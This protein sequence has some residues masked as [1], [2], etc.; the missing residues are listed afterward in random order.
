MSRRATLA[1]L[2]GLI[3]SFAAAEA[4]ADI[5]ANRAN[6]KFTCPGKAVKQDWMLIATNGVPFYCKLSVDSDNNLKGDCFEALD[7]DI[8]IKATGDM[9]V[10]SKCA[11]SGTLT[12]KAGGETLKADISA[13]MTKSQTT[14][15][16]VTVGSK[17]SDA[18][19]FGTFSAIRMEQ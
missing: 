7:P 16:G 18:G 3:A 10:N 5:E 8:R 15:I 12:L 9:S 17:G 14:I 2:A 1:V 11:V 4:K 13:N 6:G 19:R